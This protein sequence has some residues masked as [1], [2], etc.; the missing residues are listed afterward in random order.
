MTEKS[1]NQLR[2]IAADIIHKLWEAGETTQLELILMQAKRSIESPNTQRF[3]KDH[4]N[5]DC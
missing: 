1:A 3:E 5:A 4:S 2:L